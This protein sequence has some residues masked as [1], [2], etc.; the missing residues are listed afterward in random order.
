MCQNLNWQSK[1]LYPLSKIAYLLL[2]LILGVS[3]PPLFAED[4]QP[5]ENIP[6]KLGDTNLGLEA[7]VFDFDKEKGFLLASRNVIITYQSYK[8][9][10]GRLTY[11]TN[12]KALEVYDN[13][14]IS[15]YG[16]SIQTPYLIYNF[17]THSGKTGPILARFENIQMKGEEMILGHDFAKINKATF[18]TC[19]DMET[20]HYKINSK[21]IHIYPYK[22]HFVAFK[23]VLYLRNFP[24]FYFP[25]YV[26]GTNT[27]LLGENS[28]IP[29]F[30]SNEMEGF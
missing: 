7:D 4:R 12:T 8:I 24:I 1:V 13:V 25:T 26:F 23:D 15:Q 29:E 3:S 17:H 21:S 5:T 27:G 14:T 19:H 28:P 22:G 9:S 30:G 11:N 18:T 2:F 16:Q 10:A 6:F 20:P